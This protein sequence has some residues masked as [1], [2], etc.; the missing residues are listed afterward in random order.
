MSQKIT[1]TS[2]STISEAFEFLNKKAKR[3]GSNQYIAE[4]DTA[5]QSTDDLVKSAVKHHWTD[6]YTHAALKRPDITKEHLTTLF[7]HAGA[8]RHVINHP[9]VD[10]KLMH[11]FADHAEKEFKNDLAQKAVA[12]RA[13]ELGVKHP[14]VD[15]MK[16]GELKPKVL[17][18]G[19][20]PAKDYGKG[21]GSWTGD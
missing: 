14:L 12:H 7:K 19:N 15:K 20:G 6:K 2:A 17:D 16:Q 10:K 13:D 5:D 8:Y 1:D 18:L 4:S 9:L 21:S 11:H 3:Q